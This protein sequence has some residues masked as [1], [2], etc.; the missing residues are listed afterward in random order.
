MWPVDLDIQPEMRKDNREV[1]RL[2]E[3]LEQSCNSCYTGYC[4]Y[5]HHNR[6]TCI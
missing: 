5:I 3:G 2:D 1:L 4:I 6:F